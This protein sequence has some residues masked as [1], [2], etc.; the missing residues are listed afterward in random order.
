[1]KKATLILLTVASAVYYAILFF[2]QSF[3]PSDFNAPAY[4]IVGPLL[5][6]VLILLSD[7]SSRAAVPV[8]VPATNPPNRK[9]SRGVQDLARQIE[10]G[11]NSSPA[12]FEQVLLAR[13][14]EA[15]V[16][17]VAL[18]TGMEVGSVR[19]MLANPRLGPSLLKDNHLYMLLY[20]PP[21]GKGPARVRLLEDA[22]ALV[23][24]W[25][26]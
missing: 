7:M 20:S 17:K 1:M 12:Y 9:L 13:L 22:L 14:R 25:K 19:E 6:L 3:L 8:K 2:S 4:F 5:A 18:E 24:S 21:A 11:A 10:V 23:E 26:P 15:L 16:E